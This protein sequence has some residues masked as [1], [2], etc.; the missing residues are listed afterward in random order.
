MTKENCCT[1]NAVN[2]KDFTAVQMVKS[3]DYD[4]NTQITGC[5][6]PGNSEEL[7]GGCCAPQGED[8]SSCDCDCNMPNQEEKGERKDVD[9][10][11]TID[12]QKIRVNDGSKNIVEIAKASGIAIPAPCFLS[13]RKHGCCN[14][15]VVAINDKQHYACGTTSEEGMVIE[16]NRTDLIALRKE[17][18]L[19]YKER[20]KNGTLQKCG[21][22]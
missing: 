8:A 21:C 16:V 7:S 18:L 3:S 19:K 15:C 11:I 12:G 9:F 22:S 4:C 14:A 5:C 6:E 20:I 2:K 17:R 13:K 1:G 10:D